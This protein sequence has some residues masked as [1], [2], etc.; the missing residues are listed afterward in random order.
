MIKLALAAI[1]AER[2]GW[3][4]NVVY[5]DGAESSV[6]ALIDSLPPR[7]RNVGE[8]INAYYSL[9]SLH[10]PQPP[11]LKDHN[12]VQ[13]SQFY[14]EL[15]TTKHMI[16]AGGD[17]VVVRRPL[18]QSEYTYA[19]MGAPWAWCAKLGYPDDCKFGGNGG[20]SYRSKSFLVQ[21][22]FKANTTPRSI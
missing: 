2:A 15:S 6:N 19:F 7:C 16:V 1:D 18:M 8:A 21:H 5:S 9:S 10:V 3:T 22:G 20:L 14:H 12:C 11:T 13:F 17:D 4:L